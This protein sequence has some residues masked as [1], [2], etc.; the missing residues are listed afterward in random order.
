MTRKGFRSTADPGRKKIR[1]DEEIS[2]IQ[3]EPMEVDEAN[4]G[5]NNNQNSLNIVLDSQGIPGNYN[6]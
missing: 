6:V 2:E 1:K 3:V 5:D 4:I